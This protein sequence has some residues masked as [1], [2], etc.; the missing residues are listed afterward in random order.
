MARFPDDGPI[1]QVRFAHYAD[2]PH[3][4]R[5]AH[6]SELRGRPS[7][8]VG[9]VDVYANHALIF[10]GSADPP[11]LDWDDAPASADGKHIA[12]RTRGQVR[13]TRVSIWNG[14]MPLI[15]GIVFDGVLDVLEHQVCVADL[16]NITR[17]IIRLGKS[18]PQRVV[19]CA[20]DPGYASRVHVG[21]GLGDQV[22]RWGANPGR[23]GTRSSWWWSGCVGWVA[24]S[25]S[26]RRRHSARR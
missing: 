17:W 20:D 8:L 9:A 14:A 23:T 5:R 6:S 25:P 12:V 4:A 2:V 15:G 24:A 1:E 26:R 11:E 13:L 18:G 7:V 22:C 3:L 10:I 19:V 16:E 21:F